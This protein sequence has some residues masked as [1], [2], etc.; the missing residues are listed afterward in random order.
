MITVLPLDDS[1]SYT[2]LLA[3][4]QHLHLHVSPHAFSSVPISSGRCNTTFTYGLSS[5]HHLV[6]LCA[7]KMSHDEST[8]SSAIESST[9]RVPP[10]AL[11]LAQDYMRALDMSPEREKAVSARFS[12]RHKVIKAEI[13]SRWQYHLGLIQSAIQAHLIR[14]VISLTLGSFYTSAAQGVGCLEKRMYEFAFAEVIADLGKYICRNSPSALKTEH[15][16]CFYS[17][18]KDHTWSIRIPAL[19]QTITGSCWHCMAV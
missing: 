1:V 13:T 12:I 18:V 7:R 8:T 16:Q 3:C 4:H 11:L 9:H 2:K 5:Q 6:V 17:R 14:R 15:S 19:Y 10:S